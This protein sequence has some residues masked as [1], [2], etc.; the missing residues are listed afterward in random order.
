M[1]RPASKPSFQP[2]WIFNKRANESGRSEALGRAWSQS[3]LVVAGAGSP[4]IES[5][6]VRHAVKAIDKCDEV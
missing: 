5:Y 6:Q 4:L 1:M 2:G 3:G